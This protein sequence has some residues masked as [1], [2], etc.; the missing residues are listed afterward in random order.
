MRAVGISNQCKDLP[1]ISTVYL[2]FVSYHYCTRFLCYS[3]KWISSDLS[4]YRLL[5]HT[6]PER[7]FT[8]LG[9]VTQK[10]AAVL[11]CRSFCVSVRVPYGVRTGPIPVSATHV[12]YGEESGHSC[13]SCTSNRNITKMM[14]TYKIH[15]NISIGNIYAANTIG[16][17]HANARTIHCCVSIVK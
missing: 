4:T 2:L 14:S 15:I 10:H 17:T 8:F 7:D 11:A 6:T 13:N 3:A 12:G 5:P 1:T 16:N 9:I